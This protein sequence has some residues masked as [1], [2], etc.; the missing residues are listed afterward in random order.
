MQ[1]IERSTSNRD[2][3]GKIIS[4]NQFSSLLENERCLNKSGGRQLETIS[5]E[6]FPHVNYYKEDSFH[7]N[8]QISESI[9]AF[10]E[11]EECTTLTILWMIWCI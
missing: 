6:Q 5:R 3:S 7:N 9:M 2:H 4:V 10:Q 1:W 8:C 11:E